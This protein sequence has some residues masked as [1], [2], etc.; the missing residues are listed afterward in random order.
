MASQGIEN[1]MKGRCLDFCKK[2]TRSWP[3]RYY[4]SRDAWQT[5]LPSCSL[6]MQNEFPLVY[7]K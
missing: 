2:T 4:S 5:R 7:G 1:N 6:V 3:K